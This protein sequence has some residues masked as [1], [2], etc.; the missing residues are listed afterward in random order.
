MWCVRGTRAWEKRERLTPFYSI[1]WEIASDKSEKNTHASSKYFLVSDIICVSAR[2]SWTAADSFPRG[3]KIVA[4]GIP[5]RLAIELA[6]PSLYIENR[7]ENIRW[8]VRGGQPQTKVNS[9]SYREQPSWNLFRYWL[10]GPAL[11]PPWYHVRVPLRALHL[12]V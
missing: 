2:A 11:V 5:R 9:R 4:L 7:H 10:F 6:T 3:F 8:W 1:S 12:M